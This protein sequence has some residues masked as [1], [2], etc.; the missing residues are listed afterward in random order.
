MASHAR[1]ALA[2]LEHDNTATP[3][4][5]RWI[6][7]DYAVAAL[8]RHG[9]TDAWY[10][11]VD[12]HHLTTGDDTP[13]GILRAT[14]HPDAARLLDAL[15]P[16]PPAIRIHELKISLRPGCW[17]R[18]LI[19][20]N[21]TLGDL[22]EVISILFGWG[23]DHLHDFRTQHRSYSDPFHRPDDCGDE[24][25]RRLNRALPEPGS[26]ITYVYD[27]GDCWTHEIAL[28]AVHPTG[29]PHPLCTTGRGDNPIEHYHPDYPEDP[30][31]FDQDA[32]NKQLLA[33]FA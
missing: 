21:L 23:D 24:F 28:E 11:L 12:D 3:D 13:I 10:A 1:H 31:P 15:T 19:P 7:T 16:T 6:I 25:S 8:D 18:V 17:R 27:L 14:R 5:L 33:H 26:K 30:T 4:D 32:I 9:T 22:H 2:Q 20:E 29:E